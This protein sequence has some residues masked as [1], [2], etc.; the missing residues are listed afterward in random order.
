MRLEYHSSKTDINRLQSIL[1]SD[2]REDNTSTRTA[3]TRSISTRSSSSSLSRSPKREISNGRRNKFF[4]DF[5][6]NSHHSGRS[7]S[8]QEK[9]AYLQKNKTR[10]RGDFLREAR[11]T[12][13]H[14]LKDIPPAR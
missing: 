4:Q 1:G 6:L 3:S 11:C 8:T 2:G 14:T 7:W 9:S 10:E 5:D 12:S 13:E